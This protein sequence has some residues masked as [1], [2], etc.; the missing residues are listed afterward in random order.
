MPR[1]HGEE[2]SEKKIPVLSS[3][4]FFSVNSDVAGTV[5]HKK[6]SILDIL[7]FYSRTDD[8]RTDI[9]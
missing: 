6:W 3:K 1:P 4:L 7:Q 2:A 5:G 9:L 8:G